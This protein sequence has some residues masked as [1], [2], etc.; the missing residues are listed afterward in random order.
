M[1]SKDKIL[2]AALR[3]FLEKGYDAAS[4]SDVV[5]ESGFTKGGIY[6]H[7]KNKDVLFTETINYLFAEFEKWENHLFAETTELKEILEIY[8]RMIAEVTNFVKKVAETEDLDDFNF[9]Y[10]MLTAFHKFPELRKK[11]NEEHKK[12]LENF[13]QIIKKAQK[14]NII[15][16]DMDAETF[17]FMMNALGEGTMLYHLVNEQID[18]QKI[19]KKLF[20]NVWNSIKKEEL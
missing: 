3:I 6:H 10:L 7:F 18:L 12:N 13:I 20:E 4:I 19:G 17:A 8:F 9:Y 1:E 11:H 16:N 5:Q 14:Q 2:K 15:Q